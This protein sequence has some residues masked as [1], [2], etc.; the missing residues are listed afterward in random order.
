YARPSS[1]SATETLWPLGV[2]AVYRSIMHRSSQ[3]RG[4]AARG[5]RATR[6]QAISS[7]AMNASST[8]GHGL[9]PPPSP[10]SVEWDLQAPVLDSWR[11]GNTGTEGVWSFAAAEPGLHVLVTSLIH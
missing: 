7:D 4:S 8:S 2:G 5:T 9:Q 10:A 1:S 11:A 6:L 3:R